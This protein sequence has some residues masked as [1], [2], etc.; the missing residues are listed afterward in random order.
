MLVRHLHEVWQDPDAESNDACSQGENS[1]FGRIS[2]L[3][4][5]ILLR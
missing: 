5:R 1:C 4:I 2:I 3:A